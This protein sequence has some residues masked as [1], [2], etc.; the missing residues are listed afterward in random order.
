[1]INIDYLQCNKMLA[2]ITL[3]SIGVFSAS[4]DLPGGDFS[5]KVTE[6]HSYPGLSGVWIYDRYSCL[7]TCY[8]MKDCYVVD[9][10]I[11]SNP[12]CWIQ[13][14]KFTPNKSYLVSVPDVTD[15]ILLNVGDKI[16]DN[17]CWVITPKMH[18]PGLKQVEYNT[19]ASCTDYCL[20]LKDCFVV[21]FDTM[22]KPKCW[23]QTSS[24][25]IPDV[26]NLK[27]MDSATNF[28][29]NPKCKA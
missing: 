13:T 6:G 17:N 28:M 24:K 8:Y 18:I 27:S 12:P 22:S 4:A 15:Y 7:V 16:K 1:M 25:I 23:V 29:L 19:V 10:D 2:A 5:W 9:Y 20:K 11:F 14:N 26:K 21:D 3:M